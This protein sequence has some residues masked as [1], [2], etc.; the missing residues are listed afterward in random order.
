MARNETR[1]QTFTN[2]L[3]HTFSYHIYKVYTCLRVDCQQILLGAHGSSPMDL[4]NPWVLSRPVD[5]LR[6]LTSED[7]IHAASDVLHLA[8][9]NSQMNPCD[10]M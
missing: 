4:P 10:M 1:K 5:K 8:V 6:M 3:S 9:T 7:L 2:K